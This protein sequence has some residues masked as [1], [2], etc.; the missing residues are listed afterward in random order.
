MGGLYGCVRPPSTT[1]ARLQDRQAA[2]QSSCSCGKFGFRANRRLLD[3]QKVSHDCA[4][5]EE[6]F[7]EV[8]QPIEVRGQRA[9]AFAMRTRACWRRSFALLVFRLFARGFADP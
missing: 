8:T 5:G 3:V 1:H 4:I 7:R 9:S 6:V 2:A